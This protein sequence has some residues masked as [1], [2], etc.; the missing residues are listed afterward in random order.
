M[1]EITITKIEYEFLIQQSVKTYKWDKFKDEL[2]M[3][4]SSYTREEIAEGVANEDIAY[5]VRNLMKDE[6]DKL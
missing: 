6:I 5:I 1:E 3:E 4:L 2:V